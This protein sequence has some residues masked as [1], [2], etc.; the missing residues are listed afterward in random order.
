MT[1]GIVVLFVLETAVR[2]SKCIGGLCLYGLFIFVACILSGTNF[3]SNP[4]P[5]E[6]VPLVS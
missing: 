3:W 4:P 6:F 2:L 5:T 1:L